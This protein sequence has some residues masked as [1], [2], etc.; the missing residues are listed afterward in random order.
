M[1]ERK[2]LETLKNSKEE[3]QR[4]LLERRQESHKLVEDELRREMA[5]VDVTAA[6][7]E[8]DDTDGLNEEE[9]TAAWRLRELSRIRRDKDEQIAREKEIADIERRRKMTDEEVVIE[10][11]RINPKK[12]KETLAFLQR[13]YH[14]GAFFADDES[15]VMRKDYSAPTL[16]DTFN[17]QL[18]PEVMQ[19]KKFGK[20]GQTKWTHLS[21]EDTSN[22]EAGWS[23]PQEVFSIPSRLD[24][25][26]ESFSKPTKKRK[27]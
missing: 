22:K 4:L 21:K 26:K 20:A 16:D 6:V 12:E 18:L 19:V 25:S 3:K 15:D 24:P 13:Y 17:K 23:N 10:N 27:L 5:T 2:R 14:K 9:E 11:E 8:V 7:Q 1:A